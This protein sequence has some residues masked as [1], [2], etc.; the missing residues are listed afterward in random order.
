MTNRLKAEVQATPS[1]RELLADAIETMS[2]PIAETMGAPIAETI[3]PPIT[4]TIRPPIALYRSDERF[5]ISAAGLTAWRQSEAFARVLAFYLGYP[6]RSLQSDE[7]R[8]FLHHLIVMRRP[9]HVLELGTW[10][11]GT[12]EVIAR[13]LWEVNH[14]HLETID[15]FGAERCPQ[16]IAAFPQPIRERISFHPVNSGDYFDKAIVAGRLYDLVLIDGNHELEFAL[17]DLMC[18]ARLMRPGGLIVLDNVDQ[19]GPRF[20]TKL[21]L[22]R[23]PEWLDIAGV[24][25]RLDRATPLELPQ[26]SF[27]DTKF[28]LLGAPPIFAVG[29][30]P[31]SFGSIE[32][33]RSEVDGIELEL[34]A[35][36]RG[37][38]HIQV[39]SRTFGMVQPEELECRQ[40]FDLSFSDMPE[41]PYIRIPLDRA[42]RSAISDIGVIRRIEIL[43][44]F[45]GERELALRSPPLPYPARHGK[46]LGR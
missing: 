3:S 33:D 34:A 42:L 11:A 15:P 22:D 44:A 6:S 41:D 32:T 43:L 2:P 24:V 30:T 26:P 19:P 12:A 36:P 7:A 16:A 20:A 29:D 21:F 38:L 39:Y 25:G 28:Y 5:E 13:A 17:F 35:P 37:S 31:R 45:V 23:N 14:G 46:S 10:Y 9:E 40:T 27:P 4:E 1:E 8:A 18:A